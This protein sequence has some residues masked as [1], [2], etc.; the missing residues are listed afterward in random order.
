[1]SLTEIESQTDV[2]SMYKIGFHRDRVE[3]Y[4]KGDKIFP[5]TL[6][7][8][9]TSQCNR[10]CPD[11]PSTRASQKYNLNPEFI[12]RLFSSLEGQTRGLLLTGGEPTLSP[13]FSET[14]R[15]A[16][17][18]GFVDIAVVTNGS[19]LD[20][21]AVQD[22]LLRYASTIRL[23]L[24]DWERSVCNTFESTIRKIESLRKKIDQNG[25][26]L[27]IGISALTSEKRLEK[28][29][30]LTDTVQAAG[31]HWV[32]FHPLCTKWKI[33]RPTPTEQAGVLDKIREIQ[34]KS[35]LGNRVFFSRERYEEFPLEFRLYHSAY[36]LLVVGADGKNYLGPEVKYH[37]RFAAI[38]LN[39]TEDG[40]FL[41]DARRMDFINSIGSEDYSA[42]RSRHRSVLYSHFID[43]LQNTEDRSPWESIP[44]KDF[45][46]PHIL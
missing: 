29:Q 15:T 6:E 43:Y 38:D 46:F 2:A 45:Y 27:Q 33:G 30:A 19:L 23:S 1:M 12:H 22:A 34:V 14:L 18:K 39:G 5:V 41:W 11:C 28:L 40:R 35:K 31:V 44:K 36:F 24:Y 21:P 17:E 3:A 10:N 16:R 4:L 8:D 26:R 13:L 25:S 20:Q 9:I 37:P 32:Y 7:L 42:I